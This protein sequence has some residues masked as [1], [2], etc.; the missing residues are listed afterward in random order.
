MTTPAASYNNDPISLCA[1]HV[2]LFK[3]WEMMAKV[4]TLIYEKRS[5]LRA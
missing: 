2:R 5:I 1:V 4:N 3:V